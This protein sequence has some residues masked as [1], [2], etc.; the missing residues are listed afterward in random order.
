VGV[1]IGD[2]AAHARLLG[3]TA[4][5]AL[6]RELARLPVSDPAAFH[7]DGVP[8]DDEIVLCGL[9]CRV[10][11]L[12]LA[13]SQLH[14]A[15]GTTGR[16]VFLEHVGRR[17]VAGRLQAATG[18]VLARLPGGC[19]TDRDVPGA[20]RRGGFVVTDLERFS[21]PTPFVALR[22]WVRGVATPRRATA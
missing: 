7:A 18:A 21:M 6:D 16:V 2:P 20:L 12:D 19:R 11:D 9:L 3:P 15:V 10:D 14:G 17:G 5:E 4:R 8:L 22:P 1:G 13:V